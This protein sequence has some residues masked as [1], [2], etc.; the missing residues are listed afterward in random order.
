[1][2]QPEAPRMRPSHEVV[3]RSLK[4]AG[5]AFRRPATAA[6]V[7]SVLDEAGQALMVRHYPERSV[8][9]SVPKI[10]DQL[11]ARGLVAVAGK[12]GNKR[13]YFLPSVLP[14]PLREVPHSRSYRQRVL[15]LLARTA[16]TLRRPARVADVVEY[17]TT[18]ER[19]EEFRDGARIGG[20][21]RSLSKTGEIRIVATVRGGGVDGSNL[22]LPSDADPA[23][24]PIPLP[25]T[26]LEEVL[27]VVR[28]LWDERTAAGIRPR[29]VSTRD[30]TIRVQ[31]MTSYADKKTDPRAVPNALQELSRGSDP[32]LRQVRIRERPQAALW[33]PVGVENRDLEL[34]TAFT[35]DEAR[36]AEALR[37]TLERV[38][39]PAASAAHVQ[40]AIR[41]DPELELQRS[42]SVARVLWDAS[43]E[44]IDDG[45]GGSV[46]RI[47][48]V[49]YRAGTAAGRAYYTAV[50]PDQGRDERQRRVREA[51]AYVDLLCAHAE[52]DTLNAEVERIALLGAALP[53]VRM[54]RTQRLMEGLTHLEM[55]I[56]HAVAGGLPDAWMAEARELRRLSA[57]IR[58]RMQAT[59]SRA[60]DEPFGNEAVSPG[61]GLS[62]AD[63]LE[64]LLP[65]DESLER[66][67]T[68]P[69]RLVPL[70]ERRIERVP[71][72]HAAPG[73]D[74]PDFL[75][76]EFSSLLFLA[77]HGGPECMLQSTLAARELGPLR[78]PRFVRPGLCSPEAAHRLRA[79]ACLAFL[80]DTESAPAI[81]ELAQQD[82]DPGVRRSA[83]W[84]FGVLAAHLPAAL[85]EQLARA[86]DDHRVRRFAAAAA[87]AKE[88]TEWWR[89]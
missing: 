84:T 63:L 6:E 67:R 34:A 23:D 9:Q 53:T 43:R 31:E 57:S 68:R 10:L 81:E 65:F 56:G 21:L 47:R 2:R 50:D 82:S 72:P 22:Y 88:T 36:A 73:P 49:I 45:S 19:E 80:K 60:D 27:A 74:V 42:Q 78:D 29:P 25:I 64:L 54:G 33:V 39:T 51:G 87:A 48:Q 85:A 17:A 77:E 59:A 4:V 35:T 11:L 24:Y 69:S 32:A 3:W 30:I 5:V 62:A 83:L 79:V 46:P 12:V 70:L 86:D 37:R 26:W 52:W 55:E 14:E 40:Q 18:T 41:G 44:A 71:N 75:F 16:E 20:A 13:Y 58:E 76:D 7:T 66:F 89:L 38:G 28:E 61:R 1:M 15:H 8:E